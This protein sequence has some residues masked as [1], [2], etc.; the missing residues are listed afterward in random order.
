[1][2]SQQAGW[3]LKQL[4]VTR[5]TDMGWRARIALNEA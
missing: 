2:G 1:M 4:D 3:N 5:L